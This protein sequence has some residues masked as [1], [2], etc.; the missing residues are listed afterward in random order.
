MLEAV[1][2]DKEIN[3]KQQVYCETKKSI[4]FYINDIFSNT[5]FTQRFKG[6]ILLQE[7]PLLTRF[8]Y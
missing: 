7:V 1:L 2:V 6:Y 4:S 3:K 5:N 8:E